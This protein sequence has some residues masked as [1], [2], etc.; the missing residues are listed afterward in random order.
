MDK[1]DGR[2]EV[3]SL[4][5]MLM[6]S[7]INSTNVL[8]SVELG[9]DFKCSLVLFHLNYF[10]LFSEYGPH[11]VHCLLMCRPKRTLLSHWSDI[12]ANVNLVSFSML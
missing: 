3:I 4:P 8:L 2:M 9:C 5:P 6:Q 12:V 7:L 11:D 1:T 10:G